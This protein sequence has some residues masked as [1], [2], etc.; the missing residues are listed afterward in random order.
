MAPES[1][2]RGSLAKRSRAGARR[3]P[4][5][6]KLPV[7]GERPAADKARRR[8]GTPPAW[9]PRCPC[10]GQ[11]PRPR[12]GGFATP[13]FARVCPGHEWKGSWTVAEPCRQSAIPPPMARGRA[14][15]IH[16]CT[17]WSLSPPPF[18]PPPAR[19]CPACSC[20][21]WSG[22]S[23]G[24]SPPSATRATS[25]A[26]RLRTSAPSPAPGAG[27]RPRGR[28][29][30]RGLGPAHPGAL[31]RRHRADLAG[32]SRRARPRCGPLA[33]AVRGGPAAVRG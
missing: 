23:H 33:T 14:S 12:T 16:R 31:A 26:S 8:R 17:W 6:G 27:R 15:I 30:R 29:R 24:W 20:R 19:P 11:C 18:R 25:S 4:P 7:A 32:R 5:A 9:Q 3:R 2:A 22:C 10:R 21:C 28:A 13:A 1:W